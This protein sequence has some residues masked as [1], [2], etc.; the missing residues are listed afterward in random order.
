MA[1]GT[2]KKVGG[3][4]TGGRNAHQ[5]GNSKK[6]EYW[7]TS[8]QDSGTFWFRCANA[9]CAREAHATTLAQRTMASPAPAQQY[10]T[11][12]PSLGAQ[13]DSGD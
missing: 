5:N 4:A 8:H 11:R 2:A 3:T 6:Y 1:I 9:V 12:P 10:D 7:H 13:D